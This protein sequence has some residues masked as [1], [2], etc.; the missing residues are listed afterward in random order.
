MK[1]I[2]NTPMR[3]LSWPSR[4]AVALVS[5]LIVIAGFAVASILMVVVL[6]A[7]LTAGGWLWW[8]YRKLTRSVRTS[9]ADFIEGDYAV[10]SR[11]RLENR[12]IP[13]P[14]QPDH[15]ETSTTQQLP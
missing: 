12:H 9:H 15:Q 7:A 4:L 6:V 5:T 1:Q 11:Q 2:Y 3:K 13:S 8:Q 14:R 10:E